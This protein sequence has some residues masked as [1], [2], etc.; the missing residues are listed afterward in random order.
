MGATGRIKFNSNGD[1]IGTRYVV[2]NYV[3][4]PTSVQVWN[5]GFW[6]MERG[7]VWQTPQLAFPGD[8][9]A[10]V[11]PKLPKTAASHSVYILVCF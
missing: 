11:V 4:R 1:R 2:R 7:F 9:A 6:S 10:R 8:S 5:L 3:P